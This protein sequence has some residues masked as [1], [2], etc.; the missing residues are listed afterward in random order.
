MYGVALHPARDSENIDIVLG[1]CAAGIL[2]YRDRSAGG[3]G[4][5]WRGGEG[6]A[7][8]RR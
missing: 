4:G 3:G 6:D 7:G 1:V 2:V 8:A 5:R